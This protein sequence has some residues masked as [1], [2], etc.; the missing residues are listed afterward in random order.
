MW[1]FFYS[2][3]SRRIPDEDL[4]FMN[5]GYL[6]SPVTTGWHLGRFNI[7]NDVPSSLVPFEPVKPGLVEP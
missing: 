6:E 7:G 3:A 2:T 1:N 5:L 4:G